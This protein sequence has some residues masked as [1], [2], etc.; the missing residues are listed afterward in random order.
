MKI[1]S[2]ASYYGS[3][4]SVITDFVSEFNN[5]YSLGDEE[6]RFVQDPYGI[7]DLE[8]NLVENFNRHNSGYSLKK[9]KKMV[10]FYSGNFLLP[11]YEKYFKGNW[12]KISYDYINSLTDFKYNG[13]WQYDLIDRGS[14]FY[15]RKR[16]LNKLLKATVWKNYPERTLN[17]MKKEITYCSH[18]SEEKF[19]QLTRSYIDKLFSSVTDKNIIMVDQ[20]VPP[21]NNQRFIRYFN[22]IK[23]IIV[24]RDPRDIFILEKYA[25]KDGI[26][27]TDVHTFCKWFSY[28]R[29][30]RKNNFKSNDNFTYIQFEDMVYKYDET[31]KSVENW[32][33]LKEKNHF[34]KMKIFD[35]NSS[36]KNTKLWEKVDC[37][38]KE[39]KYI[40]NN[41][42][43]YLY[44]EY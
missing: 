31:T 18:P 24:D 38:L 5:I 1:I 23:A 36:I 26:I 34:R 37:N 44:N 9:F 28:T 11:R 22:D 27:P 19:L 41:L 13:W 6:F 17:T 20:L 15:F 4:S 21:S 7:A 30:S 33:G 29:D 12:K 2:C 8:Y 3:G 25:W 16:I 43:D 40:E 32:L 39:I 42:S 14:L 10:D 35:P